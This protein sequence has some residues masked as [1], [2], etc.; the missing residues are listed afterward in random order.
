MDI[1]PTYPIYN[2]G[3]N[4]LTKWDEPPSRNWS[5]KRSRMAQVSDA[6]SCCWATCFFLLLTGPVSTVLFIS[7][8]HGVGMGSP[9]IPTEWCGDVERIIVERTNPYELFLVDKCDPSP[10]IL[11]YQGTLP[12]CACR[13]GSFSLAMAEISREFSGG[14]KLRKQKPLILR[15]QDYCKVGLI[16]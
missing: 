14:P 7:E 8:S 6:L 3:Y 4:P 16:T 5:Q 1:A 13:S 10:V 9:H 15:M 11:I 2:Q 12:F